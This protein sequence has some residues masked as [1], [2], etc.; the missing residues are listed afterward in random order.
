MLTLNFG[1]LKGPAGSA[2]SR[3]TLSHSVCNSEFT[4]VRAKTK[5]SMGTR[6]GGQSHPSAG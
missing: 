6:A 4:R 2:H 1:G 5:I 3:R